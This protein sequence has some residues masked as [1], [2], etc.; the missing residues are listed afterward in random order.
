V[1]VI[2]PATDTPEPVTWVKLMSPVFFR[3]A[4][5]HD[6]GHWGAAHGVCGLSK[7]GCRKSK[8][9][10]CCQKGFHFHLQ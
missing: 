9:H 2:V 3:L 10:G 6:L 8:K 1:I 4:R 7:G 5:L